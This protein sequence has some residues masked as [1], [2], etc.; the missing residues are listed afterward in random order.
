LTT[1]QA[2]VRPNLTFD[3]RSAQG[4]SHPPLSASPPMLPLFPGRFASL[5]DG[6]LTAG[7]PIF[8]THDA[9]MVCCPFDTGGAAA[10]H[11]E[12]GHPRRT[13]LAQPTCGATRAP[14]VRDRRG[15]Y[16]GAH[17]HP[18]LRTGRCAPRP[19]APRPPEALPAGHRP[20]PLPVLRGE[21]DHPADVGGGRLRGLVPRAAHRARQ[22]LP[23]RGD[24][25]VAF[26]VRGVR[27]L[28]ASRGIVPEGEERCGWT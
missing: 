22:R 12:H 21:A 19:L 7:R 16:G 1:E 14:Q 18:L 20:S 25:H 6:V 2:R 10:I 23:G 15:N 13:D 11:L 3:P 26:L 5:K 27:A 24:G 9:P 17:H 8:D 28:A 4:N